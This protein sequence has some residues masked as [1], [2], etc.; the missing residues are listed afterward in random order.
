MNV[1]I[2]RDN[3]LSKE[4]TI[5]LKKLANES[6]VLYRD[7]FNLHDEIIQHCKKI[8]FQRKSSLKRASAT[9]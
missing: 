3:I 7:D 8:G 5:P 6:L 4:K 1:I 9:S 2:H